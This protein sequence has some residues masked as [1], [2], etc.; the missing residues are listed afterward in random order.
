MAT[1]IESLARVMIAGLL[2]G[3][4]GAKGAAWTRARSVLA[5]QHSRAARAHRVSWGSLGV[6]GSQ[7]SCKVRELPQPSAVLLACPW[8]MFSAPC[9]AILC[10]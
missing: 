6:K 8:L 10:R 3:Y 2:K 4:A 5:A 9:T 7:G 1:Q